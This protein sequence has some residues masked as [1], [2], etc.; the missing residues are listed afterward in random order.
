MKHKVLFLFIGFFL[1]LTGCNGYKDIDKR[2]FVVE[3]GLDHATQKDNK[4]AV[5]LKLAIA[6]ADTETMGSESYIVIKEGKTISEAVKKLKANVDKELDFG[7]TK[8]IIIGEEIAKE[9]LIDVM[10]WFDRRR[11]IQQI[12]YIGIGKP[13]A[14]K[15][16]DV[17]PKFERIPGNFLFLIFGNTGTESPSITLQYLFDLRRRLTEN[18]LDPIIPVV[19][20]SQESFAVDHASIFYNGKLALELSEE[21]TVLYNALEREY[22]KVQLQIENEEEIFNISSKVLNAKYKID[23]TNG[24]SPSIDFEIEIEGSIEETTEQIKEDNLP[25]YEKLA[26]ES[27][28]ERIEKLLTKFQEERVDPFGFGLRYRAT[29][30]G[31]EEEKWQKWLSLYPEVTF[32]V[33]VKVKLFGTGVIQ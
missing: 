8:V 9:G 23:T 17:K 31:D 5:T 30:I 16:I 25:K 24:S 29:N 4:Y 3:M 11:D 14:Q 7:H 21:E 1:I 2:F 6:S 28:K 32:K 13:N 19:E 12:S 20:P 33:N 27:V 22:P 15:I 10:D 26:R 18:G